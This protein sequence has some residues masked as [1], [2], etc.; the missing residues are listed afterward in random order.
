MF[1]KGLCPYDTPGA[2]KWTC[3]SWWC[4]LSKIKLYNAW[5]CDFKICF[6]NKIKA[7]LEIRKKN[8]FH[9]LSSK[10]PWCLLQM[11]FLLN[12]ARGYHTQINRDAS[13]W[14]QRLKLPLKHSSLSVFRLMLS[15]L[16]ATLNSCILKEA[17]IYWTNIRTDTRCGKHLIKGAK[18]KILYIYYISIHNYTAFV[19]P[20]ERVS[21]IWQSVIS[22]MQFC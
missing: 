6:E 3:E 18:S 1:A 2:S 21:T 12:K 11:G 7:W 10:V 19:P 13:K 8:T 16:N 17:N 4:I 20:K 14:P 9:L 22:S 5:E 15:S